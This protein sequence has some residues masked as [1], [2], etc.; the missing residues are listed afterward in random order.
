MLERVHS[1]PSTAR[2]LA[3]LQ[4]ACSW[5]WPQLLPEVAFLWA[6]GLGLWFGAALVMT[7]V[8][9][10]ARTVDGCIFEFDV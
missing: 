10:T 5:F 7:A 1:S 9:R 6:W 8:A 2:P 4:H 3:E